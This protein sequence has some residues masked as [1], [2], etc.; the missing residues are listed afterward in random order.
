MGWIMHHTMTDEL[1][2]ALALHAMD[3]LDP[4]AAAELEEHLSDGCELC[5]AQVLAFRETYAALAY[6]VP[7][8][9]PDPGLREKILHRLDSVASDDEKSATPGAS[10]QVWKAWTQQPEEE[11]HVVRSSEQHWENVRPGIWAKRLYVDAERDTV[12]M[13]VRMDPGASYIPHR[14]GGPEQCYVLEGDLRDGDLLVTAGDFQCAATG[15]VHGAQSTA[16]GCLLL[17]VSSLHDE[18][19]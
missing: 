10:A 5:L 17:I 15:S 8:S 3:L 9:A 16:G 11:V 18:L 14:H 7:A 4:A 13:L 6:A 1:L 12:T 19:L 2:E